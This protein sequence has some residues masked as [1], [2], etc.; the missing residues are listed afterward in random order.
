MNPVTVVTG[1]GQGLG[2]AYA[3]RL[4]A[5]GHAVGV[6]DVVGEA[7]EDVVGSIRDMGGRAHA[8]VADVS[9]PGQLAHAIEVASDELGPLTG[10]VANAGGA[11]FP[12]TAIEVVEPAAWQRVLDVNLTGAWLSARAVVPAFRS[13]GGGAIVT[14]SSTM[15]DRGY[16]DGL[17]PYTAAKAGVVGLTRALAHELGPAGIRV[18]AIAP[19]YIPVDTVKDVHADDD[20]RELEDQMVAEQALPRLGTPAE[21]GGVVAFLLSDDARF[22]TGQVLNVDGGWAFR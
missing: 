18:N 3:L 17:A 12:P 9:V 10:L 19:G 6:L 4:A 7:A 11:L 2:R 1:G 8:L 13:Q 14:V 21:L 22:I 15:V 16:P 20:R 5:T